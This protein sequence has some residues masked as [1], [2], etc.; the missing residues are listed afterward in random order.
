MIELHEPL[1]LGVVLTEYIDDFTAIVSKLSGDGNR[2]SSAANYKIGSDN[3]KII[4][5][6]FKT[7]DREKR[8]D[9]FLIECG[10]HYHCY[11][12][13]A[14]ITSGIDRE[15]IYKQAL[16]RLHDGAESYEWRST[17]IIRKAHQAPVHLEN[18]VA[19][20][21][22]LKISPSGLRLTEKRVFK[23][24]EPFDFSDMHPA[25]EKIKGG[26]TG[27]YFTH[28]DVT[29]SGKSAGKSWKTTSITTARKLSKLAAFLGVNYD[30]I[31][32]LDES[33]WCKSENL[34]GFEQTGAEERRVKT[35]PHSQ[36][37]S[38]SADVVDLWNAYIN[39]KTLTD[40]F[41]MFSE[42]LKIEVDH[43]SLAHIA[44]VSCIERIGQDLKPPNRCSGVG[45]G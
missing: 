29:V 42:A 41:E 7:K 21:E 32:D 28:F 37:I 20:E 33:I 35:L 43:P 12:D 45:G 44:Y 15:N 13:E 11:I 17:L 14:N 10:N 3:R 30:L 19:F 34:I 38:I 40:S 8:A 6:Q 5:L 1:Q 39:D 9:Y 4:Q 16:Q 2:S 25:D 23:P 22:Y 31:V 27:T 36:S 18:S 26:Y 24:W